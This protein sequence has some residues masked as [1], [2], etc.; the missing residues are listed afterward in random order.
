[1]ISV[2]STPNHGIMVWRKAAVGFLE[3][4][5]IVGKG[6]EFWF[7]SMV[8]LGL[9]EAA[10]SGCRGVGGNGRMGWVVLMKKY[11]PRTRIVRQTYV[12]EIE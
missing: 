5:C 11:F 2:D 4:V 6:P 3:C 1:M 7:K 12:V 10:K 8:N 9:D